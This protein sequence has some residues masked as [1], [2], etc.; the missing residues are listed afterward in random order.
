MDSMDQEIPE[1]VRALIAAHISSVVQLELLLLLRSQPTRQRSAAEIS[2]ELR[3]DQGWVAGQLRE[4]CAAGLLACTDGP[5]VAFQYNSAAP[6]EIHQ[7]VD[8]L[9]NAYAERRVTV[10]GLIF[11]KPTDPIRSFS[12]AFRLRRDKGDKDAS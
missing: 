4:L 3:I 6:P 9:E 1:D 10:I 12:D 8:G 7:A 2:R 5:N 11:S